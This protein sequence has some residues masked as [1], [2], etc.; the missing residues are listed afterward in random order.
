MHGDA[1]ESTAIGGSWTLRRLL[2]DPRRLTALPLLITG[3]PAMV[4][5]GLVFWN[6]YQSR[7]ESLQRYYGPPWFLFWAI[8]GIGAIAG[9]ILLFAAPRYRIAWGLVVVVASVAHSLLVAVSYAF[10]SVTLFEA[11]LYGTP[12]ILAVLGAIL[13]ITGDAPPRGP[14]GD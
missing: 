2:Q 5:V 1:L 8:L 6:L 10:R 13:I 12:G 4:G 11:I 3:G 9:S 7:L 14:G